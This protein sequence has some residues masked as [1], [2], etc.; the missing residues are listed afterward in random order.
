MDRDSVAF[1]GQLITYPSNGSAASGYLAIP[2]GGHGPGVVVI[3]EWWG[4]VPHIKEVADR[5]AG[6]GFVALAPDLYH[7]EET[8]EPD[9]AGKK[10]MALDLPR[11]AKDLVGAVDHVS[12]LDTHPSETVGVIGFCMGGGLA[13][14]LSTLSP[15]VAACVP[16]YGVVP[17]DAV[18]PDYSTAEAAFLGHFAEHDHS[19]PPEAAA[20]LERRLLDAGHEAQIIVYPGTDHAFFNDDRP[21]VYA[22]QA[23]AAAWDRTLGF[24][25]RHLG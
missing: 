18:Q 10:M 6:A 19:A 23:A 15:R 4:L 24:L 3:Q 22:P 8:D 17:W 1:M 16:F 2:A 20:E 25:R 14:W 9:E 7:G 13:L 5:L 12:A 21:E 11:A